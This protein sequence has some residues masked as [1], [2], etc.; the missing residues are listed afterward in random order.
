MYAAFTSSCTGDSNPCFRMKTRSVY[1][2]CFTDRIR[3]SMLCLLSSSSL[4]MRVQNIQIPLFLGIL[5]ES[6]NAAHEEFSQSK[7]THNIGRGQCR[8]MCNNVAQLEQCLLY[9][10]EARSLPFRILMG[11]CA[12]NSQKKAEPIVL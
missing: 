11:R 2:S 6:V 4:L 1:Q 9:A 12:H 10:Y 7:T 5:S 3:D 8:G